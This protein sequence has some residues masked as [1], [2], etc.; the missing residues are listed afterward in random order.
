MEAANAKLANGADGTADRMKAKLVT[1]R[2]FVDRMLPETA[3]HLARIQAGAA[4][5]MELPMEAF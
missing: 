3:T 4:T 2:F 5:T 1:G